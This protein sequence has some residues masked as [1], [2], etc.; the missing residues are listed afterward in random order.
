MII[1]A[2]KNIWKSLERYQA[3]PKQLSSVKSEEKS[4]MNSK[5]FHQ[6]TL[7]GCCMFVVLRL[8]SGPFMRNGIIYQSKNKATA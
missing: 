6:E 4:S 1:G 5:F 3:H 7:Q 2:V 8:A